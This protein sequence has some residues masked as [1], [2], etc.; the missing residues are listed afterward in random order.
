MATGGGYRL[1]RGPCHGANGWTDYTTRVV[2]V[3]DDVDP[4]QAV[5]TLA[6]ELGHIHAD[7]EHRF[8]QYA[9][10]HACRGQAEMEAESVAYLVTSEAGLDSTDY[11]VPYVAGWGD[12]DPD[13]LRQCATAAIT[14]AR[15][16][17]D[18]LPTATRDDPA[19]ARGAD[20]VVAPAPPPPAP[21]HAAVDHDASVMRR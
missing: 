16:I 19:P 21:M 5:K 14:T 9:R 8:P 10:D 18:R 12:G 20:T 1:E 15:T 17:L 13:R 7:H 11:S 6:H 2:R 3:R 4:A